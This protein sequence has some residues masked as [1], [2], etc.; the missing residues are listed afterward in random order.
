MLVANLY[1][2]GINLRIFFASLGDT[3]PAFLSLLLRFF[4]FPERRWPLKPLLLLILPLAVTLNL[5][6][7]PLLL[8]IFG[9]SFSFKCKMQNAKCKVQIFHFAF[10][11]LHFDMTS[12]RR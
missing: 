8:F 3:V 7:A 1:R 4:P 11:N 2:Y 9:T 12:L 5:F 10:F 6:V